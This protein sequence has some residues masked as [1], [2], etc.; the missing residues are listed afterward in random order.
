MLLTAVECSF[1]LEQSHF[2]MSHSWHTKHTYGL[3][4]VCSK[5]LSPLPH[6]TR[7]SVTPRSERREQ[8]A[9]GQ[10]HRRCSTGLY[11]M[12]FATAGEAISNAVPGAGAVPS[13]RACVLADPKGAAASI[14]LAGKAKGCLEGLLP[15]PELLLVRGS[16][17][18]HPAQ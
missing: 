9:A 11:L 18:L 2:A 4:R 12:H 15:P 14:V 13:A 10:G 8:F 6:H 1:P 5:H 7:A 17:T 3:W 16:C